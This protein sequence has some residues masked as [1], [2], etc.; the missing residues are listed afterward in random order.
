MYQQFKPSINNKP[1]APS[2]PIEVHEH[3]KLQQY[4]ATPDTDKNEAESAPKRELVPNR[5]EYFDNDL[6]AE[7][8]EELVGKMSDN[9][10][11]MLSDAKV[12]VNSVAR[13]LGI[14]HRKVKA[15]LAVSTSL[16]EFLASRTHDARALYRA[17][18][19][20]ASLAPE[21]R[22]A[23]LSQLQI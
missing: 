1:V 5:T 23:L 6:S 14:E 10:R 22:T 7:E 20:L 4:T 9:A 16:K 2:K 13:L 19:A 12:T 17:K 21:E 15:A 3:M 11:T 18:R 8:K